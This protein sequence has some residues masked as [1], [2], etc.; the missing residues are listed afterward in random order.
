MQ[1]FAASADLVSS[2]GRVHRLQR[3][4]E[5]ASAHSSRN[6][7]PD[8]EEPASK[9]LSRIGVDTEVS[10]QVFFEIEIGPTEASYE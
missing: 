10:E 5:I 9:P 2:Y 6:L 8:R 4:S 1:A 7:G 3:R